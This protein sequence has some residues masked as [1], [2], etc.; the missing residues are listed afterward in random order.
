[1]GQEL[2]YPPNVGGWNEG[3]TWLASRTIVARANFAMPLVEGKLSHPPHVPDVAEL[4]SRHDQP[5]E[6]DPATEWMARL[7]WGVDLPADVRQSIR[8]DELLNKDQSLSTA[9][10]LLLA[11]PEQQLA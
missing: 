1:M 11:R 6:F 2:F 8:S 4:L 3:R 9:L 7:L 10:A 5:T